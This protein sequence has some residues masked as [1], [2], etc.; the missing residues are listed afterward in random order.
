MALT[1]IYILCYKKAIVSIMKKGLIFDMESSTRRDANSPTLAIKKNNMTHGRIVDVR[2]TE[3]DS[4][5]HEVH[6]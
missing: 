5:W 3:E 1:W 2:M 6:F 4:N